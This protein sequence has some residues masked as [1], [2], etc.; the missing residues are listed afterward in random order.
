MSRLLHI[1]F[2]RVLSSL[3]I[4]YCDGKFSYNVL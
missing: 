2:V 4:M 1:I 3:V